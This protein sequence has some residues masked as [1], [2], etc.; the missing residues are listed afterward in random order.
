M[1][2]EEKIRNVHDDNDNQKEFLD[3]VT[4][5]AVGAFGWFAIKAALQGIIGWF[6]VQLFIPI[7]NKVRPENESSDQEVSKEE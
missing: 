1:T 6:A 7:W 4:T 5:T 2:T 3:P